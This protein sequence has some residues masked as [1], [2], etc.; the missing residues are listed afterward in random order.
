MGQTGVTMK[1]M[2]SETVPRIVLAF[3]FLVGATD[4]FWFIFT[5]AHLVHPPTSDQGVQFEHALQATGFF[6]PFMK[7]IEVIGALCLLTN[8]AP[9]FG[10]ALLAPIIM[11]IVLFHVFLNH[12][13]LPLAI[14][15]L[16]CSIALLRAY[17]GN[18]A[19]LFQQPARTSPI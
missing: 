3:V 18:Y 16:A 10:L 9:A 19:A 11:V 12:Q 5:G 17:R 13:G 1:K 6:W 15:L 4:G 7:T 2:L 14:I 8:R